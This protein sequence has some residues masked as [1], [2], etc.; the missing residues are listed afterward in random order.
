MHELH[1]PFVKKKGEGVT[2]QYSDEN[3]LKLSLF[4]GCYCFYA[5]WLSF[6]RE[7][8]ARENIHLETDKILIKANLLAC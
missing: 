5:I 1:L 6:L 4:H 8:I 2:V 7:E 3:A